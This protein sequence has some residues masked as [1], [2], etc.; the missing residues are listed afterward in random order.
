MKV[1]H[2]DEKAIADRDLKLDDNWLL[3]EQNN[4]KTTR[5]SRRRTVVGRAKVMSYDDIMAVENEQ[6]E[7][8]NGTGIGRRGGKGK[9]RCDE[10]T[11]VEKEIDTAEAEIRETGLEDYCHVLRF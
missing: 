2:A 1:F 4:E 11:R 8:Q 6:Q 10:Q 3:R 9:K 7:K 5:A